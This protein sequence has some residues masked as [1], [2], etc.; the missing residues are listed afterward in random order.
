MMPAI[1]APACADRAWTSARVACGLMVT[2][3]RSISVFALVEGSTTTEDGWTGLTAA[4]GR[5]PLPVVKVGP[6]KAAPPEPIKRVT[7]RVETEPR[8]AIVSM[9]GKVLGKTPLDVPV[10]VPESG[11]AHAELAMSLSGYQPTTVSASGESGRVVVK[12]KLRPLNAKPITGPPAA[13]PKKKPAAK[14]TGPANNSSKL[15]EDD[16]EVLKPPPQG[17]VLKK[18]AP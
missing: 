2:T 17:D 11:T 10:P 15:D 6:G 9:D 18:P 7:F 1:T 3:S 12:E 13:A 4:R 5:G 8:G 16:D 14:K